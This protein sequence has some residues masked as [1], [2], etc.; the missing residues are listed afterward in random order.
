MLERILLII[1]LVILIWYLEYK[2]SKKRFRL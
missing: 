2:H 1:I